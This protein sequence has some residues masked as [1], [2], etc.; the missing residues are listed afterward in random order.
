MSEL[1]FS[2]P[3]WRSPLQISG[4]FDTKLNGLIT[5]LSL[6]FLLWLIVPLWDWA[7]RDAVWW[8]S[9]QDCGTTDAGACWAFIGAKARFILFGF[10]PPDLQWRPLSV[11]LIIGALL[12]VSAM[13]RFWSIRLL[14]AWF[15]GLL[16]SWLL[17]TGMVTPPGV[18]TNQWGGLPITI[19]ISL[20]GLASAF[21][22]ATLL[23]LARRSSMGLLRTAAIVFI[24]CLRGIPLIA[25]LYVAMLIVPMALPAQALSDKLLRAQ[26]GITLFVSAYLAEVIRAGLQSVPA[27]Q[28]EAAYSLG[29]GYWRAMH[30]I[31]LPQ[32]L[33][34]VIPAIVN[35]SIGILLNTALLAVIGISDLL[36]TAK[37]AATDPN[38]LGFYSETF[39]FAGVIYFAIS[40]SASRFSQWLERRLQ[41]GHVGT[42]GQE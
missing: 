16:L 5:L 20:V 7:V 18:P 29:L 32:A 42:S 31:V 19:L 23:A 17:M 27:G 11:L 10:Y 1:Q 25:V 35:L 3:R 41:R 13:P 26:I 14:P 6:L 22:L 28:T 40:F 33:K 12:C 30:L 21:P 2:Q 37:I 15:V 4:L 9:A 39:L 24:E 8:G 38:W 36:N 34:A